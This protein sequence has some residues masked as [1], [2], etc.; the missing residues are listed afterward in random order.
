MCHP[1]PSPLFLGSGTRAHQRRAEVLGSWG[2]CD[3]WWLKAPH[4][5]PTVEAGG[6]AVSGGYVMVNRGQ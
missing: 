5:A 4:R 6:E 1:M 2:S 3:A